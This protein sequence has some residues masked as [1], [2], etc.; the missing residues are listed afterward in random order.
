MKNAIKYIGIILVIAGV[1]LVTKNLFTQD[2]EWDSKKEKKTEA[3]EVVYY[4]ARIQLLDKEENTFLTGAT[5]V[6]KNEAGEEIDKWETGEGV[7]L[8]NKLKKGTYTLTEEKAPEGYHFNE[9]VI[10]FEIANKDQEVT[11]YNTKMT[12][13]EQAEIKRQNTTSSEVGVDNT[14]SEKNIWSILG[15]VLSIGLGVGLILIQKKA[16]NNDV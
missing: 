13:E 4:N 16:P 7:H 1:L 10:S 11:M 2:E 14:L 8:V 3:T 9:E 12:E 6:I 15:G 5:L